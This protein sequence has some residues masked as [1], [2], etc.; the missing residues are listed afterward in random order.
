MQEIEIPSKKATKVLSI[1]K[2]SF[3]NLDS[4][5]VAIKNKLFNALVKPVLLYACEIW[6]PELLSYKT[7]F[8]KSTIEQVHIK[9]CKQTLKV[10]WYTENTACRVELGRYLLSIDIKS[11]I[12]N[13]WQRL[14]HSCNNVLLSEAF[15]YAKTSTTL[16]DVVI[17]EEITRGHQVTEPITRHHIKNGQLTI[18]KTLRNQYSQ[19][20]LETQNSS[21]S[22]S[23]EKFTH[24]EVKKS[25]EFENC[26]KTVTNLAHRIS[27]TKLRLGCHALRI[28]TRKYENRGVSIPVEQR[29]CL[30]C[31]QNWVE[32]EKHFLMYCQGFTTIRHEL[33][34]HISKIDVSY[35]HLSENE[36]TKY[37][38]RADNKNTLKIVRKSYLTYKHNEHYIYIF[39]F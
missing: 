3:Y 33:C 36:R 38:L 39:S 29:P 24:K 8:Y 5:T 20:W 12:F 2:R 21:P 7:H 11:S 14:K 1:I 10:P 31:K 28:Q 9:F 13:Y 22:T 26:L 37:L 34:S 15:Q 16:F 35:I 30:V 6:G 23:R 27:L 17:N 32:D 25:Y 19:N 18:R 4:A